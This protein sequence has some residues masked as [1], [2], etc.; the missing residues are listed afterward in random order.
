MQKTLKSCP[1]CGA[2]MQIIDKR[3]QWL[4]DLDVTQYFIV[5]DATRGGCGASS[6]AH[7]SEE[8][9]IYAWN[10]RS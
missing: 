8:K 3:Q 2:D 6:G 7:L 10:Q 9:A 4:D 5:C 1:F